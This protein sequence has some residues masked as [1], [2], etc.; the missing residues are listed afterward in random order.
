MPAY[1]R[2]DA[3]AAYKFTTK[4]TLQFN[5]YNLTDK[6]YFASAYTNWAVPGASRTAAL[7]CV[8]YD[9]SLP[10]RRHGR[11]AVRY[12]ELAGLPGRRGRLERMAAPERSP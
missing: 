10:A 9:R 4:V 6:Y 3:M 12:I 1:W 8:R 5:I 11:D 7:T 2:F